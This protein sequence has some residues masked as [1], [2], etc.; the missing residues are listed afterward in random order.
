MQFSYTAAD[1]NGQIESGREE[2]A[3]SEQLI[4]ILKSRGKYPL[5]IKSDV[6]W[7]AQF[8]PKRFS[9]RQRLSFTQQLGGLLNAGV[10][11]EKS[12]AILSRL[13]AGSESG[14]IIQQINRHIQEGHSFTA[15]LE[16]FPN[17]FPPL[18]VHLIQAG[19]SGGILPEILVRL[20]G[21]QEEERDLKNFIVSSLIYP[22]IL[23]IATVAT[24]I[25]YVV[26]V[27]PKFETIFAEMDSKLPLITQIVMFIGLGLKNF[28]WI[29]PLALGIGA[30]LFYKSYTTFQGRLKYDGWL[31]RLPFIGPILQKIAVSRMSMA[32]NMLCISGIPLLSALGLAA[33]VS[34]NLAVGEALRKVIEEVKAGNT[35]MQSM[36]GQKVFP[37]LALEMIG[38]GEESGNLGEML[39]QVAK[40][41]V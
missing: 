26:M 22:A 11:L 35:L 18:Y 37:I 25:F 10:S 30:V 2:A 32:L 24:L 16:K 6:P 8:T 29:L 40:T 5:E 7:V 33:D 15:A 23:C 19:E 20:T 31:L 14:E 41:Y 17:Y 9:S 13:V 12:L 4:A 3:S 21:Y 27:I 28:W 1:A 39:G 34:G 38:V 36:A